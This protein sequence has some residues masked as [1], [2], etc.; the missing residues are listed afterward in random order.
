MKTTIAIA[1][2]LAGSSTPEENR[3]AATPEPITR[4]VVTSYILGGIVHPLRR[5]GIPDPDRCVSDQV[6]PDE[7]RVIQPEG[8]EAVAGNGGWLM[9]ESGPYDPYDLPESQLVYRNTIT[10]IS[11]DGSRLR[12]FSNSEVCT[13]GLTQTMDGCAVTDGVFPLVRL[14]R[15]SLDT[16]IVSFD[17]KRSELSWPTKLGPFILHLGKQSAGHVAE[18][19]R[20]PPNVFTVDLIITM[21]RST[22]RGYEATIV[23]E[24]R[25]LTDHWYTDKPQGPPPDPLSQMSRPPAPF[26]A[27]T[28]ASCP[29]AFEGGWRPADVSTLF[30]TTYSFQCGTVSY[31][32]PSCPGCYSRTEMEARYDLVGDLLTITYLGRTMT[33]GHGDMPP[34]NTPWPVE[35]KTM[36][37]KTDRWRVLQR[38]P[39]GPINDPSMMRH[40][41]SAKCLSKTSGLTK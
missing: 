5:D 35:E 26:Y 13:N 12:S 31:S 22:Q 39:E 24:T 23:Q 40:L 17:P 8:T 7:C 28:E 9:Q 37:V 30:V 33:T 27:G 38:C 10:P 29:G 20:I 6:K 41:E 16:R 4:T 25:K 15:M 2:L 32:P 11:S 21:P 1:I 14:H 34:P 18:A 36:P 3:Q 19:M